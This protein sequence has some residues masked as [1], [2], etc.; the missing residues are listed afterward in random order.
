ML[1]RDVSSLHESNT[2][3]VFFPCQHSQYHTELAEGKPEL[4]LAEG[5]LGS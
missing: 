1:G 5:N 4:A 3:R 2:K